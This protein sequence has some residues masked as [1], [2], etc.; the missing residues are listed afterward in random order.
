MHHIPFENNRSK[1]NEILN[2]VPIDGNGPHSNLG[3][4]GEKYFLS[5]IDDYIKVASGQL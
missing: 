5:F 3:L 2:I 4:N 1:A